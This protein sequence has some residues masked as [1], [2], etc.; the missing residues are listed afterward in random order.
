MAK[1]KKAIVQRLKELPPQDFENFTYDL[2]FLSGMRNL[3]WRTPGADGGRDLEGEFT[4]QDFAGDQTVQRWY[5][6]CKRYA[7]AIDWPTVHEKLSIADNHRADFLLFVTTANFS[8]HCRDEVDRHNR[9]G[10]TVQIRIWPYFRLDQLLS[11]H[12]QLAIKY[13]L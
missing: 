7:Q 1:K 10:G 3:V 12:G 5:I 11:I 13:G 6:E 2:L 9:R 8:P 4:I